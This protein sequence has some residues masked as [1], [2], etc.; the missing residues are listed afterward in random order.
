M[1]ELTYEEFQKA[2]DELRKN[3][4]PAPQTIELT[5]QD[6]FDCLVWLWMA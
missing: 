3:E 1:E 6:A 5:G 4:V 2:I